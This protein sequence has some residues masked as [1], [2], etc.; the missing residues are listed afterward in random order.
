MFALTKTKE[1]IEQLLEFVNCV[2]R[3]AGVPAELR[4]QADAL[5]GF[6]EQDEQRHDPADS[7]LVT[8]LI[9]V[10]N[11]CDGQGLGDKDVFI[12]VARPDHSVRVYPVTA[13]YPGD[14]RGEECVVLRVRDS[15]RSVWPKKSQL[16]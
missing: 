4:R 12:E 7:I 3:E 10:L 16:L 8:E 13:I 1:R 14:V 2:S 5:L 11:V 15:H 6:E 9:D